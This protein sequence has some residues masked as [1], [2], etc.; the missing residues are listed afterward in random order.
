[1]L[2]GVLAGAH[3]VILIDAYD[4]AREETRA[5]ISCECHFDFCLSLR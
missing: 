3:R 2:F 1:M 5:R 4:D